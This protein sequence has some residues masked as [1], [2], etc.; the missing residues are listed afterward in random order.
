[1]DALYPVFP[2]T[3]ISKFAH[4][5]KPVVMMFDESGGVS[6]HRHC[7]TDSREYDLLLTRQISTHS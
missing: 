7:A 3:C 4:A 6:L 5:I 1:M 2:Q